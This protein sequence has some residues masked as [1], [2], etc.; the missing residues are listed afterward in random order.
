MLILNSILHACIQQAVDTG[1]LY[2]FITISVADSL[3]LTEEP[4][5]SSIKGSEPHDT[6]SRALPDPTE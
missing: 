1:S 5:H 3:T 2:V 6:L 4:V